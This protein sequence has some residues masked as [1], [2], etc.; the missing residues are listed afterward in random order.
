MMLIRAPPFYMHGTQTLELLAQSVTQAFSGDQADSLLQG[1]GNQTWVTPA[2]RW[3]QPNEPGQNVQDNHKE[4]VQ[5]N[6]RSD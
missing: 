1:T 3:L 5:H 6:I 4:W 2:W